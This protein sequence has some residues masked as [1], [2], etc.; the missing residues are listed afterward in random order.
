MRRPTT[1]SQGPAGALFSCEAAVAS[2]KPSR[3]SMV[4]LSAADPADRGA[5]AATE[6]AT[7]GDDR[8]GVIPTGVPRADIRQ[9][10]IERMSRCG[11]CRGRPYL[12]MSSNAKR[13]SSN[14]REVCGLEFNALNG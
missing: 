3:M 4:H 6:E 11:S 8:D 1:A 14:G 9:P 5:A 7:G 2:L 12:S 13:P 10:Q